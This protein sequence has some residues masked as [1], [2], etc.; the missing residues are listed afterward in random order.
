M[1]GNVRRK[2]LE[3]TDQ[4]RQLRIR[5]DVIVFDVRDDGNLRPQIQER[6]IGLVR[7]ADEG[8]RV[9]CHLRGPDG[10]EAVCEA[11]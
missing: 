4:A 11:P 6:E 2:P 7:F 10:R 8:D 9:T 3:R 1:R 5:G